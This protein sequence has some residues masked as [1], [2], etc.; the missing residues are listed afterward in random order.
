MVSNW[1]AIQ[2][3][4][5]RREA[6]GQLIFQMGI[7]IHCGEV[8]QGYIGSAARCE[9]AIVGQLPEQSARYGRSAQAAEILL[10]EQA[11]QKVCKMVDAE[12]IVRPSDHEGELVVYQIKGLHEFN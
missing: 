9:F 2:E 10:S 4:N 6:A 12:R 5:A 1:F 8:T 3:V 7:A 11:Y